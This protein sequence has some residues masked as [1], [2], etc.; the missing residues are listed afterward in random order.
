MSRIMSRL[1]HIL[2]ILIVLSLPTN[3]ILG[4]EHNMIGLITP[5]TLLQGQ[6]VYG[7]EHRF[8]GVIDK[9]YFDTMFGTD[10]G[11]TVRYGLRYAAKDN[12]DIDW[13]Y[14]SE[15][16]EHTIGIGLSQDSFYDTK[17]IYSLR[18]FTFKNPNIKDRQSNVTYLLGLQR[19]DLWGRV[20]PL[21]NVFYDGYN[22][23]GGAGLGLDYKLNDDM[24]LLFEW[25]T[26]NDIYSDSLKNNV[27]SM[28]YRL[29]TFGHRFMVILSNSTSYGPRR[30][31]EGTASE[32]L[33]LGFEI[34]RIFDFAEDE[35][36]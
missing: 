21:I 4:Y 27:Y 30:S 12:I 3:I 28:S 10:S 35:D 15:N 7:I 25:Y 2:L 26:H 34:S 20:T 32:D 19:P 23:K 14:S 31:V 5:S 1:L 8:R 22:E 13:N 36:Y 16:K 17:K 11:A 24:A 33:H 6:L 29:Q 18:Y 9:D